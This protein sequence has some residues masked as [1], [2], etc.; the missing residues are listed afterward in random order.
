MRLLTLDDFDF[1]LPPDLI[2][3]VPLPDRAASR[4]L[5]VAHDGLYDRHFRDLPDLLQPGD[6]LVVNDTRVLHARLFG[7][8][9]S[10]GQIEV[11][12]TLIGI[13]SPA[14]AGVHAGHHDD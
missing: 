13:S 6:L 8:K 7:R 2:A 11:Q 3:Q 14:H 12:Q 5:Q 1:H 10:G 4:L 9:A